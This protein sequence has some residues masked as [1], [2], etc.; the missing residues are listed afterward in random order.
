[1]N[2]GS[3]HRLL[4]MSTCESNDVIIT[5]QQ[6]YRQLGYMGVKQSLF[7]GEYLFRRSLFHLK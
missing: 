3:Y 2:I 6:N 1:M 5:S 4:L 7:S